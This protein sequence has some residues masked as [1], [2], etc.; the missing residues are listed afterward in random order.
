MSF[1]KETQQKINQFAKEQS[2]HYLDAAE[3]T[4][5]EKLRKK[6]EQTKQK[7]GRKLARFKNRS[8]QALEAQDD[9]ILY[10]SDYISD[11]MT[12][13]MTEQE[14][15]D[16]AKEQLAASGESELHNDIQERFR[17]YYENR[18]LAADEAIGLFY[19]GFA[20]IG[21]VGGALVG[22][23][24]SGGRQEFLSGGF[25]DTLIGTFVGLLIGTG[26]ALISHAIITGRK[27]K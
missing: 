15:F 7:A 10:M 13:G 19:A 11:L 27:R 21:L 18:D 16:K 24:T 14:A 22:Y 1:S 3:M 5:M 2:Q 12:N 6:T 20:I 9:M 8:D 17:E 25:I 23:I 4:Y 26:L